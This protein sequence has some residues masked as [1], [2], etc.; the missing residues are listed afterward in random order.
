MTCRIRCRTCFDITVSGIRNNYHPE[1]IPFVTKTGQ[2][3]TSHAAWTRARNQQRNWETINQVISLRCLPENITDSVA[4]DHMWQFEF[5]VPDLTAVSALDESMN[6][7]KHDSDQ[8][9][10]I[11]GLDEASDQLQ[12]LLPGTNIWFDIIKS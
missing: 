12:Y 2:Q 3:L 5:D 9:P 6:Y 4:Q 10:M 11:T 7:L 8:V 1:R